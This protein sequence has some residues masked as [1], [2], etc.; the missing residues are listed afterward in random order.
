MHVIVIGWIYVVFMI[1][2]VSDSVVGGLVRFFFLAVIPVGL[3][4]WIFLR[5]ARRKREEQIVSEADA[6]VA[7]RNDQ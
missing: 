2:V 7:T 5:R 6:D 3:W 4:A 1:S